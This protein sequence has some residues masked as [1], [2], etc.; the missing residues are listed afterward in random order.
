MTFSDRFYGE[1]YE[2]ILDYLTTN[3]NGM[4][5]PDWA[6]EFSLGIPK[7]VIQLKKQK[8]IYFKL[9]D[10]EQSGGTDIKIVN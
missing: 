3:L 1:Y 9:A 10:E 7:V 6:P 2:A 5:L 8:V 4:S